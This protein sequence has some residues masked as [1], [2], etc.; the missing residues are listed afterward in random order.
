MNTEL[1]S[2][3]NSIITYSG[4]TIAINTTDNKNFTEIIEKID[5]QVHIKDYMR[6]S[7]RSRLI[8][9]MHIAIIF[10][11]YTIEFLQYEKL[12]EFSL[13]QIILFSKEEL[14]I[15]EGLG[16]VE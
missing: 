7:L 2:M 15:F 12:Q 11:R 16:P 10:T 13:S 14:P 6:M 9:G 3:N 4:D 1:D 5:I 8:L